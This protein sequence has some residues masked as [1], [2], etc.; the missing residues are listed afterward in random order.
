MKDKFRIVEFD[1]CT[2]DNNSS[3]GHGGAINIS[4]G[5]SGIQAGY[6]DFFNCTFT[7][8]ENGG[9]RGGAIRMIFKTYIKG[10]ETTTHCTIDVEGCTFTSNTAGSLGGAISVGG[11]IGNF[12]VKERNGIR[13]T[14]T[15]N[16]ATASRGG[17]IAVNCSLMGNLKLQNSD[18]TGN[19]SG[20]LGGA[21]EFGND[22]ATSPL[23]AGTVTVTGCTFKNNLAHGVGGGLCLTDG[24]YKTVTIENTGFENCDTTG[25]GGGIGMKVQADSLRNT[26]PFSID[27]NVLIKGCTFTKCDAGGFAPEAY[28]DEDKTVPATWDHDRD[29]T[30]AEIDKLNGTG[31]GGAIAIGGPVSGKV[32]IMGNSATEQTLMQNCTSLNNGGAIFFYDELNVTGVNADGA[33]N[34]VTLQHLNIDKCFARDAGG[35]VYLSSVEVD[36]FLMTNCTLQN[37]GYFDET[38]SNF[39]ALN[40][41]IRDDMFS[42]PNIYKTVDG[43]KVV[44]TTKTAALRNTL[45]TRWKGYGNAALYTAF[46]ASGTFRC[47]GDTSVVATISNCTIQNNRSY[48]NGGGVYWNANR[49]IMNDAKTEVLLEPSLTVKNCTF[50]NNFA[51]HDGGGMFVEATVTVQS[52]E[53][54]NN[55]S[56]NRGGALAQHVYNNI[57][58]MLGESSDEEAT[59]VVLMANPDTPT[60]P[61]KIHNNTSVN[62]GGISI[63]VTDTVSVSDDDT[64][65]Y[66]VKFSLGGSHV[67]SNTA[68]QNGGGIYYTCDTYEDA[69]KQRKMDNFQKEILIDNGLIYE[70]TAGEEN[71]DYAG[72]GGGVFMNSNQVNTGEGTGY[73]KVTISG[74]AIYS[75]SATKGNG[76][77][78]HLQ[79]INALCKMEGGVIGATAT[80]DG[81]PNESKPNSCTVGTVKVLDADGNPTSETQSSGGNGGGIAVFGGARIEM[82]GG[83]VVNNTSNLSGGGIAVHGGSTMYITNGYVE[84]NSS[85]VGGGISLDDAH[86]NSSATDEKLK[87][88]MY[89]NGGFVKNNKVTPG[90]DGNALGG[91]ICIS[92]GSTMKINNG[93]ITGNIAASDT[94][95]SAFAANQEGG[96]IAVCQGSVMD[97]DGGKIAENKA[98]DGGGLCIRG[99]SDVTMDG[100]MT[101]N[102]EDKVTQS[103]GVLVDNIAYHNGGGAYLGAHTNNDV[104]FFYLNDGWVYSNEANNCGGG[105]YVGQTNGFE[106]NGGRIDENI[107]KATGSK[108]GGGGIYTYYAVV[109]ISDGVMKGNLAHA[110]GGAVFD[111]HGEVYISG[112][113]LTENTAKGS[114]GAVYGRRSKH[115]NV[116]NGTISS[117]YAKYGGGMFLYCSTSHISGGCVFTKNLSNQGGGMFIRSSKVTIDG[118][119]FSYN[120]SKKDSSHYPD[121]SIQCG[122]GILV[123]N[124]VGLENIVTI[125]GGSI[126]HNSAPEGG[127]I[128]IKNS[129]QYNADTA[130][131][132]EIY[133]GIISHNTATNSG[134]GILI[135]GN[136]AEGTTLNVYGGE[137]SDNTC[138]QRG[139][140]INADNYAVVLVSKYTNPTTNE[141]TRPVI[142]RNT[143]GRGGGIFVCYGAE[144]TVDEGFIT[145]NHAKGTT[146]AT[147]A[148]GLNVDN[149]YGV[150]GGIGVATGVNASKPAKFTLQGDNMAIYGNTADFGADDV[151]SDGNNTLLDIPEV[152]KMN[153]AG[154]KFM[155][156]A[157]FEDYP[158]NDTSY[159]LGTLR[160]KNY[161]PETNS[162]VYRYRGSVSI[163]R[164][165]IDDDD[166]DTLVNVANKYICI[167]LGIPSAVDD[168]VVCDYGLNVSV[169]VIANDNIL[170]ASEINKPGILSIH[171]PVIS[172]ESN[173]NQSAVYEHDGIIYGGLDSTFQS[174]DLSNQQNKLAHGKASL[175]ESS[176]SILYEMDASSL[177]MTKEDVFYYAVWHTGPKG[178]AYYYYAKVTVVPATSIYYEDNCGAIDYINAVDATRRYGYWR[179]VT[180]VVG[181]DVPTNS[182]TDLSGIVQNEDRPGFALIPEVDMDNLYGYDDTYDSSDTFSMG[183]AMWVRVNEDH[184][185]AA[186]FTFTGT[187]YDI[188][189]FCS[190]K[191]GMI[192]VDLYEGDQVPED[193]FDSPNYIDTV[194]VD[195]FYGCTLKCYKYTYT[196]ISGVWSGVKEEISQDELG[197]SDPKPEKPKEGDVVIQYLCEI[198]PSNDS[199][200]VAYQVPILKRKDLA[201]GTYTAEIYIAYS[202]WMEDDRHPDHYCDFYL[203]AI[204][205]YDPANNG[206]TSETVKNTYLQDG[207]GWPVYQELRNMFIT[208]EELTPDNTTGIVFMDGTDYSVG[209]YK[210]YGA[211]NEVYLAKNQTIGFKLDE[212]K[213]TGS[214][215]SSD[216]DTSEESI[217]ANIH[218]GIKSLNGTGAV[219]ITGMNPTTNQTVSLNLTPGNTEMFYDITDLKN[220][221]VTIK[222]TGNS[223]ISL[224]SVKITHTDE[225]VSASSYSM[226]ILT[227]DDEIAQK[228][229]VLAMDGV[230]DPLPQALT[231]KYPTLSFEGEIRYN[232]YFEAQGMEDL[233]AE[234]F[235]LAIF[236]TKEPEG[237]LAMADALIN[238]AAQDGDLMVVSTKGIPAK[239]LGDML[240][241]KVFA[242]LE[243]GEII[244]SPL[245]GYSALT[246][247]KGILNSATASQQQKALA[248]AM[249]NYGAAAQTY[250]GYNTD[251]LMSSILTDEQKAL[252]SGFSADSLNAVVPADAAKCGSFVNNDGFVRAYPTV[253]FEAAFQVQYYFSPAH[254]PE[255][256]VTFCFWSQETYESCETLTVEN[257]DAY[258]VMTVQNGEYMGVSPEIAAKELDET[259]YV[260][261]FYETEGE[262]YCSGVLA[263]SLAHYCKSHADN[264][265]SD[266]N[267]FAN[268]A[269]IYGCAAKSY[270]AQ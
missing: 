61:T 12:T 250:F 145:F 65:I 217:V 116:T 111:D 29:S 128:W 14:F 31:G 50:D 252:V 129:K 74:G 89:F 205:V 140:G 156:E 199:T 186:R 1:T 254:T 114:G 221:I 163:N 266:M 126:H 249:L 57:A 215:S 133:G 48:Q 258:D 11:Q 166:L 135:H 107:A 80:A 196:Y 84:N 30:T 127:G 104:N 115:L 35:A 204:R 136:T 99:A 173:E 185:A 47:V 148:Y 120:E 246:Y 147:T 230:A 20:S 212:L 207:E 225:P 97:I 21:V 184:D 178:N 193:T 40:Y 43:E 179:D 2:F 203:D 200:D 83:Y 177:S 134:G 98:Y 152:L 154:Y 112:G 175:I 28:T 137:I 257:A 24:K 16:T 144:L 87:Y 108:I 49:V 227:V 95:G 4:N 100:S 55:D 209:S 54:M 223:I 188:I 201:Y 210:N 73:S 88:G 46:D 216:F 245:C 244:Y 181:D 71:S 60:I 149:L 261:A 123:D 76:G 168:T 224:T 94:A 91:G 119:T 125:N 92:A 124:D 9:N 27:G 251:S 211:N 159:K 234:R 102:D 25:F 37:C 75:N 44:D 239:K 180:S 45:L 219:T 190:N 270:F 53:F 131:K 202:P 26:V 262:T 263:Y 51:V 70:N 64:V 189:S 167:T 93:E 158:K 5:D 243:D 240:Y 192:M 86:G 7:N 228:A 38:D 214:F 172:D 90:A 79:G 194:V 267:A 191:T 19:T 259:L 23:T 118:G 22:N 229:V 268:A 109:K 81:E 77:G 265:A 42:T 208:Q 130:P 17:A 3:G 66:P 206:A 63:A 56:L 218:L 242:M 69:K 13:S 150:G 170:S 171:A 222:N 197:K 78:I 34:G 32:E 58:R 247:A 182:S 220:S 264:A 165:M 122:G 232:V 15:N 141:V 256:N 139:G 142:T 110:D 106:L 10:D 8:N 153:M 132:V 82:T 101:V 237:T 143:G 164:F 187:G 96:G 241:F 255:G 151:F 41:T 33:K 18:F 169:D 235:G 157:W 117:N 269:A 155:P 121:S 67:Y 231:P 85:Y 146:A 198:T 52:C 62:G 183:S 39:T 236:S 174:G 253:S 138:G 160:N 113:T 59:N 226:N 176:A 248:V 238:G 6:V 103:D 161:N 36:P 213:Y 260:A 162:A 68:S 195:T 105:I 233:P 72:S